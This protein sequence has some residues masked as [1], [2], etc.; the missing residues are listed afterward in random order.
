[1]TRIARV[2]RGLVLSIAIGAIA[3]V[4]TSAPAW[5][6]FPG[7]NGRIAFATDA[8]REL[9][10]FTMDFNGLGVFN[11]TGDPSAPGFA[12]EPDYSPD[13]TKI[14]F[15]GGRV[16]GA[17]IYTANADGTGLTQLTS[18][19][20]KDYTPAWSPDG[21]KIAFASNRNDPDP[22]NC[23]GLF[24]PCVIDIFVMPATGG[25]PVQVTFGGGTKHFPQFSPDGE[26]I[27][28]TAEVGGTFAVY[29][30]D[31]DTL[32]VT[33]LTPDSLRAGPP[34]HSPDGTKIVSSTNNLACNTGTSDCRTA[35][36]VMNADGSSITWLTEK[37]GN[38][39]DPTWSPEGDKIV[40]T[41]AL[42]AGFKHQ[43]IYTMNPDGTDITRITFTNDESF[44]PDWGSG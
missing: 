21:S 18:N 35:I 4:A 44:G 37:F 13:G 38:N 24:G 14:A 19:A 41:H 30:V 3:L 15:R 33:K 34:D 22:T 43:Q 32:V 2:S 28:Y 31:L 40:F 42:G 20:F 27:A 26:S 39:Y 17:E 1:M 9:D 29:T 36:F 25:A 6:T 7:P 8:T 11:V 23:V 10:I 16:A 12:I 5:A